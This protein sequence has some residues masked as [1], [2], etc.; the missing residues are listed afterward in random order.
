[1]TTPPDGTSWPWA[2]DLE[3]TWHKRPPTDEGVNLSDERIPMFVYETLCGLSI[4]SVQ[5]AEYDPGWRDK[6]GHTAM[7]YN[8]HSCQVCRRM[9]RLAPLIEVMAEEAHAA[10]MNAYRVLGYSSRKAEWGEEFM[11][12]YN[13]LS[14]QGK[15][16]DRRIMRAIIRA[17]Y[18]T[19]YRLAKRGTRREQS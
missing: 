2:C 11:V 9:D 15:E 14:E 16:F 18:K 3:R 17:F 5:V 12:P 1:M 10:W 7:A 8:E 13:E 4:H 6:W 19:G